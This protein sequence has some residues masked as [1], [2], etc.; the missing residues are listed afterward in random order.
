MTLEGSLKDSL[1]KAKDAMSK[2]DT[3]SNSADK[4][5][6]DFKV[7]EKKVEKKQDK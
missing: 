3:A 4:L 2:A 6:T 7:L 5:R 1:K